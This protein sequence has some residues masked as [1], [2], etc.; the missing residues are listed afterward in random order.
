MK[1][2]V[3]A[4]LAIHFGYLGV[5]IGALAVEFCFSV[6]P[7]VAL[8]RIHGGLHLHWS[9]GARVALCAAAAAALTWWLLPAT[10]IVAAI[11]APAAYL[12]LT[13]ATGALRI[14]DVRMLLRRG[15]P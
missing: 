4:S 8:L 5:A 9:V 14:A 13:A 1:A 11:V 7:T 15:A 6:V 12:A 10:G 3:V 2:V